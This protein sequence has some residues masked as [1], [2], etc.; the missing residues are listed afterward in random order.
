MQTNIAL[1][2]VTVPI[3]A[4]CLHVAVGVRKPNNLFLET[5]NIFL[6]PKFT[7]GGL[8]LIDML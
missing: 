8:K 3:E 7:L 6:A 5:S 2:P 1:Y 4:S